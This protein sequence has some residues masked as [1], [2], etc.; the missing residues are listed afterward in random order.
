MEIMPKHVYTVKLGELAEIPGSPYAYWAPKT[1][2]ELFQ[3]YPPLD[4]DVAG[5]KEAPKIADV[6]QGLATADDSRF[7][8]FWWEVGVDNIATSRDETYH[9]KWVPFVKGGKPFYQDIQ[10]VVNWM[11]NGEEIKNYRSSSNNKLLSRPQ[12]ED[13][14]FREG[15]VWADIVSDHLLD[16]YKIPYGAIFAAGAHALFVKDSVSLWSI[17]SFGNSTI[18]WPIFQ[19]LD[20]IAHHKHIGYISQIP[21]ATETLQNDRLVNLGKEAYFLL[22]EHDTGNE[23]S[24]QFIMPWLLQVWRGFSQKWKP[25]TNHPL[26]GDFEWSGFE[27]AK[28]LRGEG[29]KWNR[30]A[31]IIALANE[32]VERESKLRKRLDEIQNAIDDEVYRIYGISEEDRRLIEEE[33]SVVAV[34]TEE[35]NQYEVML[36][37]EHIK[38]MLSYF[39]LEVMEEDEDG[40]VPL[41]DMFLGTR[42][43][44]GMAT[45]VITKLIDEFG[46]DNLDRIETELTKVLKM[47]IEDWF[48]KEFFEFHTT[49][50]RLRPVIWQISSEKFKRGKGKPA[51]SCF[52]YWHKLDEDTMP[53]VRQLYL[54]PV[55][56]ASRMEVENIKAKLS[57]VEGREKRE[58]ETELESALTKY[59]ELKA[60]DEA[61]EKLLKPRHEIRVTSKSEWVKE[62]VK[63]IT[64]DGYKPERDY[65]V[66]VNIEPL[67]QAGV[68]AK[69]A[70]RVK[71]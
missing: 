68:T 17:L 26:A 46:E 4:R 70:D 63:E 23:P 32:C 45:R 56:E 69:T 22:R 57:K 9:K 66:R 24:T 28:E 49:L 41:S 1:L 59:E 50:Y 12:N 53:K 54:K 43:E 34:E 65:G 19:L 15:L 52:I 10:L 51:F 11:N 3:K 62:K 8:R 60:L 42:K 13:F 21:I 48:A 30:E 25:V 67:K 5:Q 7:T 18:V 39:G 2:R 33:I 29:K 27:S 47:T 16:L 44:P 58:V 36:V 38:R 20:P 40:I 31:S 61:F 6:K 71:G 14:Y 64:Q 37:E 55:F 35:E